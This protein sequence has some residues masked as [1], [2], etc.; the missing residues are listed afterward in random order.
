MNT[1]IP[2]DD[3]A[4]ALSNL[5]DQAVKRINGEKSNVSQCQQSTV[6]HEF[7]NFDGKFVITTITT[8]IKQS[9]MVFE[10]EDEY[11]IYLEKNSRSFNYSNIH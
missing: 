2:T 6:K 3:F 9:D 5:A 4:N 8:T 11:S 1:N 10:N 7:N